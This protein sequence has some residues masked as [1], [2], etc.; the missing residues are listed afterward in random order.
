MSRFESGGPARPVG[1]RRKR[2]ADP[3]MGTSAVSGMLYRRII[4]LIGEHS[5]M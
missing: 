2:Y 3:S 5:A 1:G 4:N